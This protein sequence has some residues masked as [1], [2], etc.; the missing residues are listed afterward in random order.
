MEY[1]FSLTPRLMVLGGFCMVALLALLFAL[2][3]VT[4]QRL[5]HTAAPHGQATVV[6]PEA[7]LDGEE[8]PPA[9]AVSAPPAGKP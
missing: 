9:P 5:A 2:G 7:A 4:G 3:Y 6:D 8:A 1:R